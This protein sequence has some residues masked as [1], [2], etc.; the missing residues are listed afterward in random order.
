M[1]LKSLS[2]F[3]CNWVKIFVDL[4]I[5]M[6]IIMIQNNLHVQ[7]YSRNIWK[8]D[9]TNLLKVDSHHFWRSNLNTCSKLGVIFVSKQCSRPIDVYN[10]ALISLR[11]C[12]M[13][14][15]NAWYGS[16]FCWFQRRCGAGL[17]WFSGVRSIHAVKSVRS[18]YSIN[19]CIK[20]MDFK[21][22]RYIWTRYKRGLL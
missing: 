11:L 8:R 21:F 13:P 19:T 18:S 9:P 22:P 12:L 15:N 10:G 6:Y 4:R 16:W 3:K 20:N 5:I 2:H 17:G 1:L 7:V 14:H